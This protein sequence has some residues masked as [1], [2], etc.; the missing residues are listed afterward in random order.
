VLVFHEVFDSDRAIGY[1]F[2]WIGL[3]IFAVD[4]VWRSRNKPASEL[5]AV[6]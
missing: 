1:I 3:A 5:A 4:E 6:S 2:I